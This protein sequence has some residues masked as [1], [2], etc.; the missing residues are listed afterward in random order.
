MTGA[1]TGCKEV[2]RRE[3]E[4]IS[5]FEAVDF[6]SRSAMET[7][8]A[9]PC[10]QSLNARGGIRYSAH[11][12]RSVFLM[13]YFRLEQRMALAKKSFVSSVPVG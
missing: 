6:L 10:S 12:P 8:K 7:A 5:A 13:S 2:P 1:D 11:N 4:F 9:C 3:W